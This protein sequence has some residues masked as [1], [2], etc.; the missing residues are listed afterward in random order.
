MFPKIQNKAK[1]P[2]CTTVFQR[3]ANF[4]QYSQARKGDKRH[5]WK[6]KK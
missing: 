6:S 2:I 5:I 4:S 1:I 3:D